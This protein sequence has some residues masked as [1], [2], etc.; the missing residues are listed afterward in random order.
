ME[1]ALTLT[2]VKRSGGVGYIA[3][4]TG[5]KYE[6]KKLNHNT[7]N[8]VSFETMCGKYIRHSGDFTF[9]STSRKDFN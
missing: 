6:V 3:L 5:Q 9:Y 2:K 8:F 7:S 4:S 1:L